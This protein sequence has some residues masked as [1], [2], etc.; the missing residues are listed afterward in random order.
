M[1]MSSAERELVQGGFRKVADRSQEA[2]DRFYTHLFEIAPQTRAL[3]LNDM[4]LQGAQFISK[5]GLIVAE[6]QNFEGL[7]PVLEDLA[8]RHV[9]YGVRPEHYPSLGKALTRMLAD[10]LEDDYT[11]AAEAAWTKAYGE[12]SRVMIDSAYSHSVSLGP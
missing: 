1:A 10:I 5:L 6:L 8:L 2:A 7:R 4:E 9:A 3:F 12:I 11:P